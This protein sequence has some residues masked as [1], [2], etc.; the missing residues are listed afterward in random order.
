MLNSCLSG[1]YYFL[2]RLTWEAAPSSC[3]RKNQCLKHWENVNYLYW[4]AVFFFFLLIAA[5][6]FRGDRTEGRSS[7]KVPSR[8]QRRLPDTANSFGFTGWSGLTASPLKWVPGRCHIK[9]AILKQKQILKSC[10]S[11]HRIP[12]W[13]GWKHMTYTFRR[14]YSS[15]VT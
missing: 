10:N 13:F 1:I 6:Y 7:P 2:L 11:L 8:A 3:S 15:R 12:C 4:L 14:V 9:L 5:G